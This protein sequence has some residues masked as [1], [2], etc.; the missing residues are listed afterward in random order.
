M[1][2]MRISVNMRRDIK[3]KLTE[4]VGVSNLWGYSRDLKLE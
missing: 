2:A 3:P 4:C 1:S